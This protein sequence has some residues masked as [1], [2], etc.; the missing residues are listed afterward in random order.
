MPNIPGGPHKPSASWFFMQKLVN[1]KPCLFIDTYLLQKFLSKWYS[2]DKTTQVCKVS[3]LAVMVLTQC[4]WNRKLPTPLI[5]GFLRH[6]PRH[7][8]VSDSHIVHP[9]HKLHADLQYLRSITLPPYTPWPSSN[10]I[11][12]PEV[13]ASCPSG[14]MRIYTDGSKTT[15]ATGSAFLV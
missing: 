14:T 7:P 12:I 13:F 6:P 10:S 8:Q 9:F 2:T 4:Y 15:D 1:K 5:Q 11:L 3:P